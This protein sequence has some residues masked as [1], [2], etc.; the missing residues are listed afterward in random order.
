MA[1]RVAMVPLLA[2][3]PVGEDQLDALTHPVALPV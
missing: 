2:T 3:E 1:G